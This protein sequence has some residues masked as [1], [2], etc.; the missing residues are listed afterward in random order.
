MK[1][2]VS[3]IAWAADQEEA[4]TGILRERGID[5]T[6]V[7]PTK[8]WPPPCNPT[9]AE[10]ESVRSF[11]VERKVPIG[12]MQSLLFGMPQCSIFQPAAVAETREYLNRV[13]A[14]GAALGAQRFVFGS[15]KNR[16]R[17]ELSVAEANQKAA[18]F[19]RAVGEA[20]HK[21]GVIFCLEPNPV[22]YQCNFMTNT[23]EALA[24][25]KAIDH[26]G[27][28]LHLDSGIM[29][30]NGESVDECVVAAGAYLK[31]F[32]VSHPQLGAVVDEG[33]IDH[34]AIGRA[35]RANKYAGMVSVEMRGAE[36]PADN[37]TN[38]RVACD[39]LNRHYR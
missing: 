31:H 34:A 13:V 12:A 36:N 30:L 28:G 15:P 14:I 6:E 22:V 11:W 27:I 7:A 20:A 29:H 18:D 37:L 19:F 23:V 38:V 33:P 26:P 17:G 24:V 39:V 1:L 21:L 25:V 2:C 8:Y 16:D 4:I 9:A 5:A 10:I 35:L 32:H 3:N